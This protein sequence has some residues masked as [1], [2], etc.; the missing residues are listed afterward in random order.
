V[1]LILADQQMIV[2]N[3]QLAFPVFHVRNTHNYEFL[4]WMAQPTTS[5]Y[6]A[7]AAGLQL[8]Y[9][10]Q[11]SPGSGQTRACLSHKGKALEI[12]RQT[13]T[14]SPKIV[15]DDELLV[16]LSLATV[17]VRVKSHSDRM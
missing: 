2:P 12:L 15:P 11:V 16:I 13:L 8:L 1:A 3:V 14:T 10:Q 9:D 17:E 5:G 7:G 4:Q 6:H